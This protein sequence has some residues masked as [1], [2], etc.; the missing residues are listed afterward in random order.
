LSFNDHLISSEH[1]EEGDD[2]EESLKHTHQ[3]FSFL[4]F[5]EISHSHKKAHSK[6]EK[7]S[8]NCFVHLNQ[9][10]LS[11]S[12][13]LS[14]KQPLL[15]TSFFPEIWFQKGFSFRNKILR[16]PIG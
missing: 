14:L 15:L 6:S 1:I 3:I 13:Q 9:I 11:D 10:I 12:G 5:L 4:S 16:P 7:H 8:E 2:H